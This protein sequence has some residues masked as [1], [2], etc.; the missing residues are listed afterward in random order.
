MKTK[1]VVFLRV[2]GVIILLVVGL[3]S[4]WGRIRPVLAETAAQEAQTQGTEIQREVEVTIGEPA[5]FNSTP[6]EDG[7]TQP[8]EKLVPS[9]DAPAAIPPALKE[10]HPELVPE[11]PDSYWSALMSEG[12]EGLWPN[13]LWSTFDNNGTANGEYYWDDDDYLPHTD[14]WSAWP[15]RGGANGVDPE[16]YYYPNNMDSWMVY[17]PFDLSNCAMA[18]YVF[19]YWNQSESGW[20]YFDWLASPNGS[21][22]YGY[23]ISG[24]SGGWQYVDMN[25]ASYLGDSSVWLA[26]RFTSDSTNVDDGAFVDDITLWCYTD[27]STVSWTFMVYLDGDNNLEGAAIGDFLEMSS[28]GSSANVDIVV[29]LDRIGGFS[30]AYEDWTDTKRFHVTAGMTPTAASAITGIGEANMGDPETLLNFVR[31]ARAAYPAN[32]YALVLWDH[33]SGW[34]V[35]DPEE[36]ITKGIAYDDTSGGDNITMPELRSTLSTLTGSGSNPFE[37]FGMDACLMAMIEVDNQVRPYADVRVGSQEIEPGDGWPYDTILSGLVA[38]PSWTSSQLATRIVDDYYSSYGGDQTQSA[39]NLGTPYT[40]LNTATNSFAQALIAWAPY[41]RGEVTS[42]RNASQ[43]FDELRYIDLWDFADW[44]RIYAAAS[45]DLVTAAT[46]AENAVLAAVI[47][48]LSGPSWPYAQGISIYFPKTAGEYDAR[49]DGS[50]GFLQFTANTQWDEWVHVYHNLPYYPVNFSKSGPTNGATN[51]LLNVT[52]SWSS[53]TGATSYQYCYDTSNDNA[54]TSWV[55]AGAATSVGLSGLSPSTTYYWQVRA[56]N[57]YGTLYANLSPYVYWSFTTG[58]LPGAF[59]KSSPASGATGVSLTPTLSWGTSTN[60]SAYYY[61]Y[62]S[63]NDNACSSWTS[64]GTST[65]VTLPTLATGTTYYW[66]VRAYNAIGTTYSNGSLTAYWSFTTGTLPGAFGKLNP[67][68]G[69]TNTATNPTLTWSASSGVTAYYYCYDDTNDGACNTTWVY[70]GGATSA[71]LSGLAYNT[72][73]YWHVAATNSIGTTYAEG[74]TSAFWH[75]TTGSP[76]GAFNKTSPAN[77]ATGLPTELDLTWSGSSGAISYEVCIDSTNDNACSSW[78]NV[79]LTNGVG[80]IGLAYNTPYYWHVRA[81]NNVATTYANGSATAFWAFTTGSPPANF[82]KTSPANGS[83]D[84][85]LSLTLSWGTS[86]YAT[87]YEY[88]FDTINDHECNGSWINVGMNTSAWISGLHDDTTY[89]W[90]VR[91]LNA[92]G[93]MYANSE[94]WWSF[95]TMDIPIQ[96]LFL[97]MIVR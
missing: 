38:S 12:F 92:V 57:G 5:V 51:Q 61:C 82:N 65:S 69:A 59:N 23:G 58:P 63:T 9:L 42:A 30:T 26:F 32:N 17:G 90:Q 8:S 95:T 77:G 40:S 7:G 36:V 84:L 80:V 56:V 88:C 54:C 35:R 4:S 21:N 49:Y 25:L 97:P 71:A 76:P 45:P 78:T 75:F 89:Y 11:R 91:A 10:P 29:Q 72:T 96:T 53:S 73:Y 33:G 19:Y 94:T 68:N 62:D 22:F 15:A 39:V 93:S 87:S 48:E 66:H 27:T 1:P 79:G 83:I 55:N 85:P 86:T 67:T 31:W 20:D 18:E 64:N 52:L 14:Y 24:D 43:T 70:V 50:S 16:Y 74:S 47:R 34:T 46:S 2:F 3:G 60:V 28:V 44:V 6:K 37:L 81:V 41:Y 13:G